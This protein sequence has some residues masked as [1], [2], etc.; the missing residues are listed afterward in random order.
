[1]PQ[2]PIVPVEDK[3]LAPPLMFRFPKLNAGTVCDEALAMLTVLQQFKVGVAE[4]E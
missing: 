4:L 2:I 1:V 3:V